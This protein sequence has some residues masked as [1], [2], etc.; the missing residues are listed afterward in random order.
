MELEKALE[1]VN[2]EIDRLRERLAREMPEWSKARW[3]AIVAS[4]RERMAMVS[5]VTTVD[6]EAESLD[7]SAQRWAAVATDA[8]PEMAKP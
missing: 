1:D 4:A 6:K 3:A 5:E 8:R 7:W 2:V